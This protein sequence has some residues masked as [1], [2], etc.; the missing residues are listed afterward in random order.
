[1][2]CGST[3]LSSKRCGRAPGAGYAISCGLFAATI[4][5]L[6]PRGGRRTVLPAPA[7]INSLAWLDL[8]DTSVDGDIRPRGE[9]AQVRRQE[10]HGVRDLFG[11]AEPSQ[12]HDAALI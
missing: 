5:I 6:P 2:T 9:A 12:R 8:V 10:Q 4:G 3:G 1:M 7:T 11:C